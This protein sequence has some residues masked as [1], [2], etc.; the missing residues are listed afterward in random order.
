VLLSERPRGTPLPRKTTGLDALRAQ[1][2]HIDDQ[3]LALLSQRARLVVEVGER[4]RASGHDAI[5]VPGRE[6]RIYQRLTRRNRGPLPP[7]S[8]RAIFREVISSCLAMEQPL[9]I[10]YLGPEA[11][12]SH[13]AAL[14]QFGSRATLQP[15]DSIP[16]VFDEV[17]HRRA[18]YGVVPVENSTQ[19]VVAQTLDRFVSSPLTIKA[20]LL[21]RID[22][23]LLSRAGRLTGIRR[24][25]SHAQSFGQCRQWL[26]DHLPS[27]PLEEVSSNAKA[28]AIAAKQP[29]TAAI[30]G[31]L[32]AEHYDLKV[33]AAHIQDQAT[34]LTRFLV[35]GH[36]GLAAPT[37]ED[38]TT[39]LF[40]VRHQPGVLFTLL[41]P[42]ADHHVNLTSIESRPMSGRPW[43]YFFFLDFEGHA[44][45]RRVARALRALQTQTLTCRVVG[46]YIAARQPK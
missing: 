24:V 39:V 29:G 35:I 18:D 36:D 34:N 20:E 44:R 26:A 33:V 17:E 40:S 37:G 3:L 38:K 41:K 12:F 21:L 25:V 10:A 30:A 27:V 32:A 13:L 46:S 43:E 14:E 16:G 19:G 45:D 23:Y 11:T 15:A 4:K 1:I 8:V 6:K 2:D 22:H 28:A 31:R 5:Y 42:F 7:E 9:R